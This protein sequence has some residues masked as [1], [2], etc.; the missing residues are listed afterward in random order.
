MRV[1]YHLPYPDTI[2]GHRTI[3]HGFKNAF[4]DLG[5]VFVPITPDHDLT[6]RL[7]AEQINLF[8]TAS[9]FVYRKYIDYRELARLR[10]RGVF[11][12]T[13]IDFWNSPLGS[14]RFNEAAFVMEEELPVPVGL[15]EGRESTGSPSGGHDLGDPSNSFMTS[16]Y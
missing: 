1:A 3:Y 4:E 16:G 8:V 10:K 13:K 6:A 2:Y 11:V 12:L 14:M 7:E 9:H 15:S 5:H